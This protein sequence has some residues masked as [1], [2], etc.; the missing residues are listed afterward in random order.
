MI[1][2]YIFQT[3]ATVVTLLNTIMADAL[4]KTVGELE[5]KLG[6]GKSLE[7]ATHDV[8]VCI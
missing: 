8:M 4:N 2:L 5:E 3:C 6:E 1:I 7:A